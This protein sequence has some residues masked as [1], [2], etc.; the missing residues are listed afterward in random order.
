MGTSKTYSTEAKALRERHPGERCENC[1]YVET[2]GYGQWG[3][4]RCCYEERWSRGIGIRTHADE[5][6]YNWMAKTDDDRHDTEN[7]TT[8]AV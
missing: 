7:E 6:C 2:W 8:T 4:L 1:R 3:G 5:W